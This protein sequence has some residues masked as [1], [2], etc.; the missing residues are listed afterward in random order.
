[1]SGVVHVDHADIA[2]TV[3]LIM[4]EINGVRLLGTRFEARN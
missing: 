4:Q 2:K 3:L 1:M